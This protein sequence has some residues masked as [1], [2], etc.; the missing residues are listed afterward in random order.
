MSASPL[1]PNHPPVLEPKVGV[2]FIALGTPDATD[3]ASMRRYLKEF[4]SDRRVI[5]VNRVLWWLILNGIILNTRP[6]KSGEAYAKIWNKER[7]E[8]PLR[9]ITRAQAEGVAARLSQERSVVLSLYK[10]YETLRQCEPEGYVS[11]QLGHRYDKA[12]KAKLKRD[13]AQRLVAMRDELAASVIGMLV[14]ARERAAGG[15][16]AT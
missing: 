12:F 10:M 16:G 4:L 1:P 3:P 13:W 2:L 7:N 9:T 6:K 11:R 5:D 8:S 15:E 14:F